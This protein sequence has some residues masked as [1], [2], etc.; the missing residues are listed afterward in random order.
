MQNGAATLV[1]NLLSENETPVSEIRPVLLTAIAVASVSGSL[2]FLPCH[3]ALARI[4][5]ITLYN[6]GP[7][8]CF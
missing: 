6:S 4:S 1:D 5:R 7:L 2:T 8:V 3:I